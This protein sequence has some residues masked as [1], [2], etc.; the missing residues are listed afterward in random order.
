MSALMLENGSTPRRY[1]LVDHPELQDADQDLII[2]PCSAAVAI[3]E[4]PVTG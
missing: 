4:Q 3:E 1:R 2:P